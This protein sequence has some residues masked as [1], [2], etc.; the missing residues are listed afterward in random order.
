MGNALSN[1]VVNKITKEDVRSTILTVIVHLLIPLSLVPFSFF[2]V[3]SFVAK[4]RELSMEIPAL[5]A[6]F[7]NLS[8]FVCQ[9]WYVYLLILAFAVTIDAVICFSIYHFKKKIIYPLWSGS[10]ILV[11]AICIGLCVLALLLSLHHMSNA[12][13]LCPI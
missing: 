13:Q 4:S 12:P 8:A 5:T 2:V 7:F 11:E 1:T 10:V 9:Y 3:P 6:L